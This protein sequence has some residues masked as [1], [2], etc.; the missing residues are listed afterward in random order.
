[1]AG[2]ERLLL[3]TDLVHHSPPYVETV[4]HRSVSDRPALGC[5]LLAGARAAD[6][7]PLDSGH[8]GPI[9]VRFVS[10]SYLMPVSLSIKQPFHMAFLG[11]LWP[12]A[13]R[14]TVTGA[15]SSETAASKL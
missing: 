13:L 7:S 8:A 14:K 5:L 12:Q 1:M 11:A 6:P 9:A 15:I 4:D 2:L 3:R 10:R